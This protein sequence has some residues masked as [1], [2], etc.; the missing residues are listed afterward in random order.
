MHVV[1]TVAAAG[2]VLK[3]PFAGDCGPAVRI[4]VGR[5]GL[6]Y[7]RGCWRAQSALD[8]Y[9]VDGNSRIRVLVPDI[10]RWAWR[11]RDTHAAHNIM[12]H[13]KDDCIVSGGEIGQHRELEERPDALDFWR[14]LN[15]GFDPV[16]SIQHI[17]EAGFED[18]QKPR[19]AFEQTLRLGD[20]VAVVGAL[21]QS[22]DGE[23]TLSAEAKGKAS[24]TNNAQL[25]ASLR[26]F[27][28]FG[29]PHDGA[30]REQDAGELRV[31]PLARHRKARNYV[32]SR[33]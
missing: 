24:I 11:L 5:Q 16:N 22:A 13:E 26:G 1:G 28:P 18:L 10:E 30:G 32:G 23:L 21:R 31:V 8:F 12:V 29:V 33:W 19:Q 27:V 14:R 7:P 20:S 17:K 6:S 25:A 2:T 3:S 4:I 9:V 15:G